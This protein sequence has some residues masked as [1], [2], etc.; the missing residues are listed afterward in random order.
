MLVVVLIYS[1]EFQN[2]NFHVTELETLRYFCHFSF[3][4]YL[5][6]F[7]PAQISDYFIRL[8]VQIIFSFLLNKK[9][10]SVM[11]AFYIKY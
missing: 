11:Q 2:L 9:E 8:T 6:W 1:F 3:L 5:G 7:F 10:K 4:I